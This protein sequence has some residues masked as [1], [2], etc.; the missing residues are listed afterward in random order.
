MRAPNFS[1]LFRVT[2]HRRFDYKPIYYDEDKEHEEKREKARKATAAT[3]DR[4][5]RFKPRA[6]DSLRA[7]SIRLFML[8]FILSLLAY[9]IITL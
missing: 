6:V 2:R 4:E 8:V 5:I 7:S 9:L 3:G 1:S